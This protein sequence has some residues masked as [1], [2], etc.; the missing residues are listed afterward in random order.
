[1]TDLTDFEKFDISLGHHLH[2]LEIL[3]LKFAALVQAA[4]ELKLTESTA[5]FWP[6]NYLSAIHSDLCTATNRALSLYAEPF[7]TPEK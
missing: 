5:N 2:E 7:K 4:D 1:M 3:K 6:S